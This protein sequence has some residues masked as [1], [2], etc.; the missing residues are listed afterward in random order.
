MEQS[1]AHQV[2]AK[3]TYFPDCVKTDLL[4]WTDIFVKLT[5]NCNFNDKYYYLINLYSHHNFNL[6]Y[7]RSFNLFYYYFVVMF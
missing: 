1:T 2:Y 6:V 5:F 4:R 7:V 3:D